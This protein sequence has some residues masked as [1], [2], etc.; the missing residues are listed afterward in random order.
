[1]VAG[2]AC[3]VLGGAAAASTLLAAAASAGTGGMDFSYNRVGRPLDQG[4][5]FA[6]G[7]A[8]PFLPVF[9]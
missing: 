3:G 4:T 7:A 5:A 8:L 2:P 6:V 9:G 1:M